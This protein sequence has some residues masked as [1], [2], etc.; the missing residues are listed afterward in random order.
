M[1]L[2]NQHFVCLFEMKTYPMGDGVCNLL[3]EFIQTNNS[4]FSDAANL[5]S[6]KFL[7][8]ICKIVLYIQCNLLLKYF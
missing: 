3:I 8:K 7:L 1:F 2:F 5:P 4:L 6:K